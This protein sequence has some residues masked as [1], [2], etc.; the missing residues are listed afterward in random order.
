MTALQ[1]LAAFLAASFVVAVLLSRIPPGVRRQRQRLRQRDEHEDQAV[2]G[3]EF[4]H[5]HHVTRGGSQHHG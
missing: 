3:A 4:E 1:I 2:G 5:I